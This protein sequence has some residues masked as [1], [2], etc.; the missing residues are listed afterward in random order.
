[1]NTA[2]N[3]RNQ[4]RNFLVVCIS[5]LL[6][7]TAS[8][9]N[10]AEYR[11]ISLVDAD[12]TTVSGFS[13]S[14]F[15]DGIIA[16][17][18]IVLSSIKNTTNISNNPERARG[19]LADERLIG[20]FDSAPQVDT[21]AKTINLSSFVVY[22]QE[23]RFSPP[24]AP[25]KVL[26]DFAGALAD[27][28]LNTSPDIQGD[29]VF[30]PIF[31]ADD[32]SC[33]GPCYELKYPVSFTDFRNDVPITYYCD[34]PCYPYGQTTLFEDRFLLTSGPAEA[35]PFIVNSDGSFSA[36][37]TSWHISPYD[38][39]SY[40]FNFAPVPEPESSALL[41]VGLLVVFTRARLL[42]RS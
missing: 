7:L 8:A 19:Q 5:S 36:S 14:F 16:P 34:G 33:N 27:G 41:L 20:R 39:R 18:A 38:L 30:S 12:G 3:V 32:F 13:G 6:A 24:D 15:A 22:Y 23:A 11:A 28:C 29:T 42:R 35:V 17:G 9:I 21:A 26:C 31:P 4:I 37:F 2:L 1:M 25:F 40:T 10:A